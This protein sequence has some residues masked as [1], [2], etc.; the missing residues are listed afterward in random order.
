M[1]RAAHIRLIDTHGGS[2]KGCY[3]NQFVRGSAVPAPLRKSSNVDEPAEITTF[4]VKL[5]LMASEPELNPSH[6][7]DGFR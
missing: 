5:R 3:V 6:L 4:V 2:H 7:G 1:R